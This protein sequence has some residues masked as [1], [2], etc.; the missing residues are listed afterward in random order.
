MFYQPT[1]PPER[2]AFDDGRR[3]F[4]LRRSRLEDA[5]ALV[6]AIQA[7]LPE[8]RG[9]MPWSHFPSGISLPAQQKRMAMLNAQWDEGTDFVWNLFVNTDGGPLLSGCIG[10][11]PRCLNPLGREVGYWVRTDQAGRG[12]GSAMTWA[13]AMA[14][15]EVMGLERL[16]VGCDAENWA[17]RRVI[18]KV[19]FVLEGSLDYMLP[20][21]PAEVV[22]AGWRGTG[23]MRLYRLLA[24][25]SVQLSGSASTRA[26]VKWSPPP[27]R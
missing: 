26:H 27:T 18:E 6:S 25:E 24:E 11:H 20:S 5:E 4:E 22:A 2:I 16:Q 1:P 9:F 3:R 12:L 17:S 7:S 8:L 21:A 23:T 14:C 13:V 19:G 15:F 10:L